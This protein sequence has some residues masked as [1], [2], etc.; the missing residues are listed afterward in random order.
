ML[1][2]QKG[3]WVKIELH[4]NP[5]I[6]KKVA[7]HLSRV[8]DLL[9]QQEW[10]YSM[11]YSMEER[12]ITWIQVLIDERELVELMQLLENVMTDSMATNKKEI[13]D[14]VKVSSKD[15]FGERLIQKYM[16]LYRENYSKGE[17]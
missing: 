7:F 11:T 8:Y 17:E 1:N 3:L 5:A 12:L 13:Y 16:Q 10:V 4:E 6:K 2:V 14:K 15:S 9:E